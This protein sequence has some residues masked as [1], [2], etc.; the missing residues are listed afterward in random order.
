MR[1]FFV[2]LTLLL[3]GVPFSAWAGKPEPWQID[4]Q[5]SATSV[6]DHIVD[7]HNLLLIIITGI[8]IVVT[9]LLGYALMRY[10][11]KANPIP[12]KVTHNVP[13]EVVWTLIPCLILIVIAIPSFKL[14]YYS[15]RAINP[16]MTL[17]VTGY[18]W[19]WGYE[20]PDHGDISFLSYMI[21][22]QEIREDEGQ[23]RL[24]ETDN[25]VVVPID[26]DIRVLITAA[27]VIHAWAVPAFGVKKDAVPGRI[28]ETWFNVKEPGTYYGQCSE[29]CGI[30]HA[31]MPIQIKA[32]TKAEFA[33]WVEKAKVEFN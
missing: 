5:P 10:R 17:K 26:T 27:D 25:P 24:L 14:M 4:F 19:Y 21:P 11:R 32:V 13:L 28:N 22:D 7:F 23:V 3:A 15:D 9:L 33:Q 30:N 20:Y 16:E 6:K 8:V 2:Y 31:F 1:K 29:I 18:Q 12:S